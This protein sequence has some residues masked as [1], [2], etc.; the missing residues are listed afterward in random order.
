MEIWEISE[1]QIAVL[2]RIGGKKKHGLHGS[3]VPEQ[4]RESL[5]K[6]GLVRRH[7]KHKAYLHLTE[8]GRTLVARA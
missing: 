2:K 4:T 8:K 6:N 3:I 1:C 7:F 5:L